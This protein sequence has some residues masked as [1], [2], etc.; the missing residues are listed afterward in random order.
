MELAGLIVNAV[1]EIAQE[2]GNIRSIT[3]GSLKRLVKFT[4]EGFRRSGE[5]NGQIKN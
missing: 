4:V 2:H 1:C 3:S 5:N